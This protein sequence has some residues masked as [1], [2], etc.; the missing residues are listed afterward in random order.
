MV[1]DIGHDT[2]RLL[3]DQVAIH[4][5]LEEDLLA[6]ERVELP[7]VLGRVVEG[8]GGLSGA[9]LL[10]AEFGTE[11]R[12]VALRVVLDLFPA[13]THVAL[14]P[15]GTPVLVIHE[16]LVAFPV[17]A[18]FLLVVLLF[19]FPPEVLP[20]VAVLTLAPVMLE[21]VEGAEDGLEVEHVEVR[22]LFHGVDERHGDLLDAV[23]EGTVD[24]VVTGLH[25]ARELLAELAFV[26]VRPVQHFHVVV[27]VGALVSVGTGL[28][29]GTAQVGTHFG[30]VE[31][32]L[33]LLVF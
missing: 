8:T 32:S 10:L 13:V 14:F 17:H 16:E 12:L 3:V 1:L 21:L 6:Q 28:S 15:I 18:L 27:G 22:V 7:L 5:G 25:S 31:R 4:F 9:A 26:F 24:A 30:G 19:R 2:L 20:V 11:E 33:S 23:G 29:F